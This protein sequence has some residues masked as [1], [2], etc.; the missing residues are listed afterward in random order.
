MLTH[1]IWNKTRQFWSLILPIRNCWVAFLCRRMRISTSHTSN[2]V[3]FVRQYFTIK[4]SEGIPLRVFRILHS[5]KQS[6]TNLNEQNPIK[7][8][9]YFTSLT[10]RS[11][12]HITRYDGRQFI[13]FFIE[14]S[15]TTCGL[16]SILYSYS[17][18]LLEWLRSLTKSQ[19]SFV[20][21]FVSVLLLLG[22]RTS[23]CQ[24]WKER[25]CLRFVSSS[26][27][28]VVLL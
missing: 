24:G 14:I 10:T 20:H 11:L 26:N 8:S 25:P 13:T 3:S 6:L 19:C 1:T 23:V 5:L 2:Y 9:C 17:S 21:L 7:H 12:K 28:R 4:I 16:S 18:P 27:R 15:T 22:K